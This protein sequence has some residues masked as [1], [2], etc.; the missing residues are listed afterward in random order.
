MK[1]RTGE[2]TKLTAFATQWPWTNND[3]EATALI[4]ATSSIDASLPDSE[5]L[6]QSKDRYKSHGFRVVK[7]E[8]FGAASML[9]IEAI[10][11]KVKSGYCR[12]KQGYDLT[13]IGPHELLGNLVKGLSANPSEARNLY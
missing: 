11:D 1:T 9:C 8:S 4:S 7:E 3:D 10:S 6:S 13:F 5:W 2:V 12:S